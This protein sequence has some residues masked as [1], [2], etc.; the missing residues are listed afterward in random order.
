MDIAKALDGKKYKVYYQKADLSWARLCI[1][2]TKTLTESTTFGEYMAPDCDDP[3][4]P[5]WRRSYAVGQ[6]WSVQ[7][8]GIMDPAKFATLRTLKRANEP[9]NV[10]M[11]ED[12][13]LAD[14]GG[15]DEGLVFFES[16]E[17][18]SQNRGPVSFSA[19][20]RGEAELVWHAAA[21]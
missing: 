19:T 1:I 9:V 15:Y 11:V 5:P 4:L 18:T 8:A 14:G 3:D 17:K 2:E 6:Q 12:V 7:V 13:A 16:L 21:A 20:L 10:R